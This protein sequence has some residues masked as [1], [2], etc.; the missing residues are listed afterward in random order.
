[1]SGFGGRALRSQWFIVIVIA[2]LCVAGLRGQTEGTRKT[3]VPVYVF[4]VEIGCNDLGFFRSVGGLSVETDVVEYQDGNERIVRKRPGLTRYSNIILKRGFTGDT[5]LYDWYMVTTKQDPP[6]VNGSIAML[7]QT[8]TELA[9]WHFRNAY[10]T[11]WEG[12][13]FDASKNEVAIESIEI[14]HEGFSM[15]TDKD[16]R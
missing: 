16:C 13:D 10:P 5:A 14:A 12:P 15:S 8:G 11:K 7:D 3:P 4:R 9:T 1:M 2:V 6:R